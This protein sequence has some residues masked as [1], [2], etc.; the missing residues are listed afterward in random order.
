M[1]S[2]SSDGLA[3]LYDRTRI[4]DQGCFD[5]A[6]DYIAEQFLPRAYRK[7]FELG[8]GTGRITVSLAEKGYR[9][10]GVDNS[11]KMLEILGDSL[12]HMHSD[13]GV[14]YRLADAAALPFDDDSFD[15]AVASQLFYFLPDWKKA[16]NELLRVVRE[17]GPIILLQTGHGTEVPFL[18][19]RYK[20]LCGKQ[21][22]TVRSIGASG[23]KELVEH[24]E[25]SGCRA[26]WTQSCWQWNYGASLC[27][28]LDYI[29]R[30]AYS[31]T[32]NVPDDVHTEA[33]DALEHELARG[34]GS[35][36]SRVTVPNQVY[37]V[38]LRHPAV[39]DQ[40]WVEQG[41]I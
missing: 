17:D 35:L 27:E 15:I 23:I 8:I 37:I 39:C 21:G 14:D 6:I 2:L 18:N 32:L 16:V 41:T 9:V 12:K 30:R 3:D 34:F 40:D 31:F 13:Y 36:D 11:S 25:R 24:F 20:E 33:I 29:R 4:C 26:E 22:H 5:L 38:T 10:T 7:L 19:D 1:D 28:A